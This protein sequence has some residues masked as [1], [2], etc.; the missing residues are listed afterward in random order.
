[1]ALDE[2]RRTLSL[3]TNSPVVVEEYENLGATEATEIDHLS[4]EE[5]DFAKVTD[6]TKETNLPTVATTES[7]PPSIIPTTSNNQKTIQI[8]VKVKSVQAE[9]HAMK[10]RNYYLKYL[11][12]ITTAKKTHFSMLFEPN[13]D[14]QN[15]TVYDSLSL[16]AAR[17]VMKRA[18]SKGQEV[19]LLAPY[20]RDNQ[21]FYCV[22]LKKKTSDGFK[23]KYSIKMEPEEAD[24]FYKTFMKHNYQ[25]L[26]E[27]HMTI[28]DRVYVT[29]GYVQSATKLVPV[30]RYRD[31]T[32][33]SLMQR[34]SEDEQLG[35]KLK[36]ISR[37]YKNGK[38]NYSVLLV[39]DKTIFS[40]TYKRILSSRQAIKRT[41]TTFKNQ[42]LYPS[43]IAPIKMVN[44]EPYYLISLTANT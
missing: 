9:V 6:N 12:Y 24:Q 11:N 23:L 1:M 33:D 34:I 18:N 10:K 5:K 20:V 44:R 38:D 26:S 35:Y 19:Y 30:K 31:L 41:L 7:E 25:L 13:P 8:I 43:V 16:K 3:T 37:Y 40:G 42:G 2:V 36:D 27:R 15:Y 17:R 4:S 22:G 39:F 28:S 29:L 21:R 14:S 32:Y